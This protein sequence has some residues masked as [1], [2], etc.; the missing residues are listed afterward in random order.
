MTSQPP[1][2]SPFSKRST[3]E[4]VTTGIDLSGK[5]ALVTGCNS[6]IGF[7]TMRVLALRGAEVIGTARSLQ[8]ARAACVQ[9]RGKVRALACELADLASVAKCADEIA[10]SEPPLD[11][12]ICNAGVMMLPKLEQVRGIEKQFAT[13]HVGHFLLVNRL[14]ERVKA[15]PQGRIV[16]VSSEGHRYAPKEGIRFDNLSGEKSYGPMKAYGQSKLANI[17]FAVGLTARL[18]KNSVTANAL[19]PGIIKTNLTRHMSSI[20]MGLLNVVMVG[21]FKTIPQGAATTCVVA[22]DPAL[23]GVSGYYFS[24]CNLAAPSPQARDATLA[25]RLWTVSEDL[26][27]GYL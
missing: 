15:S 8:A 6:G 26:V 24:D 25:E 16:L 10:S 2:K 20:L 7:E 13:N 4:E 27:K 22:A 5:T 18:T 23:A 19:H 14:L 9:V 12:L 1:L 3:A 21:R 11:M 17:L